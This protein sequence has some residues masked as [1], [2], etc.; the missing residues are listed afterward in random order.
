MA[1][2][3]PS[4]LWASVSPAGAGKAQRPGSRGPQGARPLADRTV[5]LPQQGC[6]APA[7][8]TSRRPGP[9]TARTRTSFSSTWTADSG[10]PLCPVL[11]L[12]AWAQ[13]SVEVP[14]P[15]WLLTSSPGP[16]ASSAALGT[17]TPTARRSPSPHRPRTQPQERCCGSVCVETVASLGPGTVPAPASLG[18]ERQ[19]PPGPAAPPLP[20]GH[21]PF[22][23][24]PGPWPLGRAG[25][26]AES[27]QAPAALLQGDTRA[28]GGT[29]APAGTL[30][31]RASGLGPKDA[32]R[33]QPGTSCL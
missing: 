24:W 19:L 9:A 12:E 8:A 33:P 18:S 15:C 4:P 29:L 32:P 23:W 6:A 31:A 25:P 10:S 26:Q 1:C 3:E 27:P 30:R 21:S 17:S 11:S 22:S 2:S 5:L 20:G 16:E 7:S 28:V 13:G 14:H